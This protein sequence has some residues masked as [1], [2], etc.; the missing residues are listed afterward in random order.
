MVLLVIGLITSGIFAGR[1]MIRNAQLQS[2][3]SSSYQFSSAVMTFRNKYNALPGDMANATNFWGAA[4]ADSNACS[5]LDHNSPSVGKETCNGNGNSSV[6]GDV[7]PTATDT[8]AYYERFRFWQH[9]TNGGILPGHYVGVRGPVSE[10]DHVPEWNSPGSRY[11]NAVWSTIGND[12]GE[13]GC[14]IGDPGLYDGCQGNVFELRNTNDGMIPIMPA[15][16]AFSIDSKLD[17][18]IPSSGK[19]ATYK[20]PRNPGCTT[21]D[22]DE[23]AQYNL[24]NTA[25]ACSLIFSNA[26]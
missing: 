16:D 23:N 18:G 1:A 2:V 20:S 6:F 12:T 3:V 11:E 24:I 19:V 21:S 25:I 13:D 9:L 4:A 15:T 10:I 8:A 26:Y 5:N 17:D 7:S 22:I 14:Y